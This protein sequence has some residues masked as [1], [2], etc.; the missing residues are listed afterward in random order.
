MIERDATWE[1]QCTWGTCPVCGATPGE[2]CL[3]T[4]LQLG[5]RLDGK[6][7]TQGEGVHLVRI[8]HAPR[9]V[10]LVSA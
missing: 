10:K 8:Q 7:M 5:T 3:P 2:H 6:P 9:R 4:S 1:E